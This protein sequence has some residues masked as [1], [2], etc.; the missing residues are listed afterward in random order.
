MSTADEIHAFWFGTPAR[1]ADEQKAKLRR[2]YMGGPE[3]D[4]E[5][6]ERFR[7]DVDAAI[8]GELDGWADD[9][10]GRI[11]LVILLD[12]F[13]R[14]VYRDTPGAYA[15]DERAQGLAIEAFDR[16]L[17][18]GLT[19]DERQ[20]LAMPLLHAENLALQQRFEALTERLVGD[21]PD[22][23]RPLYGMG[24]EQARKYLDIITRFGR[25]PHRN[26]ILG[27]ESTPD[28]LAFLEDWA[29]RAAPTGMKH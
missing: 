13:P 12:Q 14:S 25:F 8:A 9:L 1:T 11:A 19:L 24:L 4:R 3:L 22:E 2:W 10:R 18:A 29:E 27:R 20:F 5:I 7:A 28:E 17:D 6:T 26:A 15:G 23:M 16:G 21:A